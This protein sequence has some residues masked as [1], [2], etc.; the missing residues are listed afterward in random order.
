MG[1]GGGGRGGGGGGGRK[2]S[3]STSSPNLAPQ[4]LMLR[5]P[6]PTSR[7]PPCN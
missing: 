1:G 2:G 5:E 3:V 4:M 7:L 6:V